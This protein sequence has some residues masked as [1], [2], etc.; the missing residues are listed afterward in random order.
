MTDHWLLNWSIITVSL[1]STIVLLWLGF[2]IVLNAQRRDWGLWL[3]AGELF[4]GGIFFLSHSIILDHGLAFFSQGLDFWWHLGWVPITTIP[5]AWY[6]V[7]LWFAGFWRGPSTRLY[8]RHWTWF[9]F[10]SI[11]AIAVIVLIVFANPLPSFAQIPQF[12]WTATLSLGGIP[13]LILV[14]PFYIFVCLVLSLD[15]LRHPAPSERMM[16]DQA[17]ERARPWLMAAT[18]TQV[19]VS[20]FVA[21]ALFW[22]VRNTRLPAG[23]RNI[24]TSIAWFD[25]II[26]SLIAVS[27]ILIGQAVAYYEIFTG[28]RLPRRDLARHWRQIVILSGGFSL[29]M[30]GCLALIVDSIYIVLLG[31]M[32][33]IVSLAF[34]SWRSF[35]ERE[36]YTQS[37]RPFVS[38]QGVFERLISQSPDDVD[39][40]LPFRVL[41]KDVLGLQRAVLMPLGSTAVIIEAPLIYPE[42]GMGD[43]LPAL[44]GILE[45]PE[46]IGVPLHRATDGVWVWAVPLWSARGLIGV[47]YLGPKLDGGL[48]AQEEIDIARTTGERLIDTYASAEMAKRL[49][50]LQ[51]QQMIEGQV[52]D[53]RTRRVLHDEVL[54]QL[55]AAMLA[56]SSVDVDPSTTV[57]DLSGVHH[58]IAELLRKT[59]S[60]TSPQVGELGVLAA[61][62]RSVDEELSG[63]FDDVIWQVS[64][65]VEEMCRALPLLSAE[66]LFYAAREAIRNA[67]QHGRV[68]NR[69]LSLRIATEEHGGY[70]I[71]IEDDGSGLVE[72]GDHPEGHGLALHSTMMALI[73]GSLTVQSEGGEH[74]RVVLDLPNL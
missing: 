36:R 42:G 31:G 49:M 21:A 34:L 4:M 54:P 32:L 29:L 64:P 10:A 46:Q 72:S 6:I 26:A 1:F 25:L 43:D 12:E 23:Y 11:L 24:A 17:R 58:Q 7:M 33:M 2:T 22:V 53:R 57:R 13:V 56:L 5:Y 71:I 35:H 51:R 63:A 66:V 48:Y 74:T 16:G 18:F 68:S 3:I 20:L 44:E 50:A 9:V 39:V 19:L 69:S 15:V 27:V 40:F 67:A 8:R 38:S 30:G 62:R 52:L 37:L 45:S 60:I 61:L 28:K 70:R 41:C 14:Y 65:A 73:G 55:H 59:P 47:L